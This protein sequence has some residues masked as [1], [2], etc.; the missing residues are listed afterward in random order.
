MEAAPYTP[1]EERLHALIH[2]L[3]FA[4]GLIAMPWLLWVAASRV[5][6][7]RAVGALVFSI[8]AMLVFATSTLY[9]RS[10]EPV[11]R[12]RWRTLDHAAIYLLIAGSY[13]PFTIGV[14]RGA[15]GWSL[16]G[17]VWGIAVLGIIA[18]T[19]VGFRFPKLSTALYLAMG[20]V[21]IIAIK[22]MMQVLST[23][24][25]TWIAAGG[26]L[27]TAGVPF[28]VWKSRRYTHAVWHLTVLGGV[29]CHFMA[30][31]SVLLPPLATQ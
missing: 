16:F 31:R 14:L 17:V 12:Q 29:C 25:L 19:T 13:T 1:F 20:W 22:P 7:W 2:G 9:H 23:T 30:V 3:G 26:L 15:W 10:T 28:Y 21:G 4:G 11:A 27:Y 5:D 6:L 8:S 24:T 18:K